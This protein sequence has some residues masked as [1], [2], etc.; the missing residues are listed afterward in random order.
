MGNGCR[1]GSR[2]RKYYPAIVTPSEWNAAR[3][4]VKAKTR[5]VRKDGKAGY[6]GG[7]TTINSLFS[8]LVFDASNE[9]IMVYH[10]KKGD[11]A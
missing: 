9:V 5:F 2:C 4:A 6:R 10:C 11:P 7:R 8:P 1:R 3:E